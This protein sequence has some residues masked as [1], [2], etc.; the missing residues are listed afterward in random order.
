M[1]AI[2]PLHRALTALTVTLLAFTLASCGN[3]KP[4]PL[5]KATATTEAWRAQFTKQ[6]L[7]EYDK[8][9]KRWNEYLE[10]SRPIN[11][12][13]KVT[14]A[15]KKV[16]TEYWGSTGGLKPLK[17]LQNFED[18]GVTLTGKVKVLW[19]KATDVTMK[20]GAAKVEISQCIDPAG[21]KVVQGGKEVPQSDSP[22]LNTVVLVG[23]ENSDYLILEARSSDPAGKTT[24]CEP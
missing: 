24:P 6:Q 4:E 7:V 17:T 19:S 8:A 15:A 16:F 11:A 10:K 3:D 2:G 21:L 22:H 20:N 14:P 18:N 9:F 1:P 23:G 12:A 13:G 5:P